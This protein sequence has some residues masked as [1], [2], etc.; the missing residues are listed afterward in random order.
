MSEK[1]TSDYQ[2]EIDGE[3]PAELIGEFNRVYTENLYQHGL[4]ASPGVMIVND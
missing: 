2:R 3:R 4:T 1:S